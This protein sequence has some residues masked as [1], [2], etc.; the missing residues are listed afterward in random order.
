MPASCVGRVPQHRR[1]ELLQVPAV[2]RGGGET[3]LMPIILGC[4][5][6]YSPLHLQRVCSGILPLVVFP[7]DLTS[8]PKGLRRGFT[9]RHLTIPGGSF[10]TRRKPKLRCKRGNFKI[11]FTQMSRR[12]VGRVEHSASRHRLGGRRGLRF[13]SP[14]LRCASQLPG[15]AAS[16][17][18]YH[19]L[20][21]CAQ[22]ASRSALIRVSKI[23]SASVVSNCA[24][25]CF[26]PGPGKRRTER[27][28]ARPALMTS[29]QRAVCLTSARGYL[30][31]T[32]SDRF[33]ELGPTTRGRGGGATIRPIGRTPSRRY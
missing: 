27:R 19:S 18:V 22:L 33:A 20:G 12:F 30:A 1:G 9:H 7:A 2:F 17:G 26:L 10:G 16:S 3:E 11:V 24:N 6:Y 13:C 5:N 8:R 4:V 25:G 32:C 23:R 14:A 28:A 29:L 15:I 21:Q 31:A